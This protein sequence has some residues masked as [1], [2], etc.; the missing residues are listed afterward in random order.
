MSLTTT[1]KKKLVFYILLYFNFAKY[2]SFS[3]N[4]I[5]NQFKTFFST[6]HNIFVRNAKLR[7]KTHTQN[8]TL[9]DLILTF[10]SILL[11]SENRINCAIMYNKMK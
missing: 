6:K 3:I 10:L 1:T 11:Q 7:T 5:K 4:S 2:K 9:I 8:G